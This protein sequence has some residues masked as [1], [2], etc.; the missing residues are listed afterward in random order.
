MRQEVYRAGGGRHHRI[1]VTSCGIC[2]GLWPRAAADNG[3][4]VATAYAHTNIALVKYWG[5]RGGGPLNLPAVGSLS[6]TLQGFG[7]QTTV[8]LEPALSQDTLELNGAAQDGEPVAKVTRFLDLI[9]GQ[10]GKTTRAR[11]V[12]R[13]D[14]PTAAGLASSASA[15]AALAVAGAG[16]FGLGWDAR[17]LSALARQG[18]G[19][20]ARSLFG[21]FVRL[22]R[23]E[24]ADGADCVATPIPEAA[25]WDIRLVVA[26]CASGP[27]DV[28][29]TNGM[30]LTQRTS[31]YFDAWVSTH[32][33]D[34][35]EAHAAIL[36]RDLA[37][38][39]DVMEFSTLKMHASGM[40]ARPGVLYWRGV[41]VEAAHAV[42]ALRASGVGAWFTMDAGPHVK[43]LTLAQDAPAVER[44][45][46]QVPGVVAVQ[47][48][49]AGP[50]A[51]LVS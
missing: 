48:S 33:T 5:K 43:V 12:S 21:G 13:N 19:S 4:H 6:L 31:P 2:P 44:V 27:K 29:S 1:P 30:T 10:V 25:G 8:T 7:T 41:T 14:V 32:E 24:R 45:L 50:A 36:E 34:L 28:S 47:T 46:G 35:E 17:A 26:S 40:A 51:R 22:N 11:V 49:A 16:A 38:L 20:A 39:G 3:R 23:G 9:R 18:S 37:R 15:F 42:R